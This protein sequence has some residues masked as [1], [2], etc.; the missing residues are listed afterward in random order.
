M[1]AAMDMHA[2]N[3]GIIAEFRE[4]AG[5]VGGMFEGAPM[6]ILHTVGAKSGSHRENPL[7]YR[8]EGDR[9]FIFASAAGAPV[10]PSWYH[11]LRATPAVEIEVGSDREV[12]LARPLDEPERSEVYGRQAA[13]VPQ[14]GEYEQQ[15]G[16]RVIPVVE[17]VSA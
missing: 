9:R 10:H 17:L 8:Q 2:F 5:K 13:E 7:M 14:F 15:A 12:V 1:S 3:R 6:L 4:N 11:N 16:D